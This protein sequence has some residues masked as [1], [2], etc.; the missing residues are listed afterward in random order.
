MAITPQDVFEYHRRGR[1][2]KIEVTP[3]KPLQT[4]RDLSLAYT[5]GVAEAVLEIARDP[6]TAYELTA[7]ANLVGVI[8]NGTAILG[9]GDRGA[10]AGKPVMEGKGVLFKRFADIDVFDIEINAKTVDEMVTVIRALAPTFGGINLE[11]IKA[12]ECFE[13][14]RILK[15]ELDIPVFHDDQ[16]GTAIISGAALLNAIKVNG[17]R[18][19]D[20][21]IVVSGAGA[22]AVMSAEFYVRLGV[23]RQN[24]TLTDLYGVVYPGRPEDMDVY[25]GAFAQ[26][27]VPGKLID[28][29]EGADVFLGL[30]AGGVLKPE[31]V[32][33][34]AK[35]PIIFALAN[36][37]PEIMPEVCL[38]ARDDVILATGRS[39]YPNQV[40]N[41]LGFPFIFRGALD[42][43]ARQINEDMKLAATHA[44][45]DL[46]MED[47]P[48]SVLTAYG[49]SSL[50]FGREYLI[51]KPLDPRVLLWVAP[52]IAKAAME[53]GVARRTIDL[54]AYREELISRQGIGQQT[55]S[56]IIS[57]AKA[58][59]T[60]RVIYA[61]G[62]ESKVIRAAALVQDDHL[63]E[64]ILM[65]RRE[66]IEQT[67][68]ELGLVRF[69]PQIVDPYVDDHR[70]RYIPALYEQRQRKGVTEA[71]A[72]ALLRDRNLLGSMMLHNGEADAF[73]SGLTYEY[74]DVVRPALQVFHTRPGVTRASGVYIMIVKKQVYLFTDATVNVDP[75]AA[76]LAEIAISA[77]DF[78]TALD[79]EPRVAMLSFSNFGSSPHPL[80]IKVSAAV[81]LV[82]QRRPEIAIDG[83]MQAD[84]AVVV[85]LIES[86]YPFSQ[87]KDAN[88]LVFPDLGSA[89]VAYK[90]LSRLGGAETIG[91]IL[92]GIGAP[93]HVLQAGDGVEDIVAM[94]AVAV[95]DAQSRG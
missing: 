32:K 93:V 37:T 83:E 94:T 38:A 16:H 26:G 89:N 74:P 45:A 85:D 30:S 35:D 2:G 47:V 48:D 92:L 43:Y 82:R 41:V 61:E 62:D 51:P 5:P 19:S 49:L 95:M 18:L 27:K 67:I 4:Q 69:H 17:K 75:D 10:L 63:A 78:A 81:D 1:P 79:I 39:D 70:D 22:A 71:K 29:I 31:M 12:P 86:R 11:D 68:E 84:T 90:L 36:P 80:S 87:V 58:G 50:R 44:L 33:R 24:I 91:P 34:M 65:G 88:V 25:K 23:P 3:T 52:A 15:S 59:T 20:L 13:V 21:K 72:K 73:I 7:K 66:K 76:T 60:K 14:E 9:L 77:A 42:V 6:L 55:R 54:E 57:K 46:T 40:N 53:S 8:S 56:R 64:P 28:V